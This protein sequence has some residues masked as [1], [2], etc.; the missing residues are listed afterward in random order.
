MKDNN[1]KFVINSKKKEYTPKDGEKIL[2]YDI[3]IHKLDESEL[4]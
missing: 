3:E 4:A 1:V 2:Y